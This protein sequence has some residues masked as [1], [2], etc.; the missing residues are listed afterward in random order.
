MLA[1]TDSGA[2]FF[3]RHDVREKIVKASKIK[4]V[5][6]I[7]VRLPAIWRKQNFYKIGSFDCFAR[8]NGNY[9]FV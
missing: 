2:S 8:E 5:F 1:S 9:L 3:S 6:E 7:I 4:I